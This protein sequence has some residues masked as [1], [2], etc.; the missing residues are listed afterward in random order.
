[1]GT[2]IKI[3]SGG[4]AILQANLI[5]V[6]SENGV[7]STGRGDINEPYLTPE[8]ALSDISNTG[9]ITGDTNSS[10]TLTN[11]SDV[12]N[13]LL[14]VGMQVS[15]TGIG[16]STIITAKGNE[17]GDANTITLSKTATSSTALGTITF[18]KLYT[19]VLNGEFTSTGNWLK[20]GFSYECGNSKIFFAGRLFERT[21]SEYCDLSINGGYWYGTSNLSMFYKANNTYSNANFYFNLKYLYS[22]GT[23][24]Q[25][26]MYGGVNGTSLYVNCPRFEAMFGKIASLD[27]TN[28]FWH[29]Y[30]YGLL[31]GFRLNSCSLFSDGM[32]ETPYSVNAFYIAGANANCYIND[33]VI[34]STTLFNY[35]GAWTFNGDMDGT[36]LDCTPGNYSSDLTFNGNVVYTTINMSGSGG[37]FSNGTVTFNGTLGGGTINNSLSGLL[38][39]N[40]YKGIYVGQN[41][42][43]AILT[44]GYTSNNGRGISTIDLNGTAKLTVLSHGVH[45]YTGESVTSVQVESGSHLK[46]NG[47][48]AFLLSGAMAGTLEL[49]SDSDVIMGFSQWTV[50]DITGTLISNGGKIELEKSSASSNAAAT[51]AIKLGSGGTFIMDGGSLVCNDAAVISGLIWKKADNSKVVLKGQP[52]LKTANGLAPIQ[53]TSNVGTAQ[54]IINF[55]CVTNGGVGFRLDD[56]FSDVTHGATYAPNILVGGTNYEDTTYDF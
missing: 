38:R 49:S 44:P 32:I 14:E 43:K 1:M 36:T 6:D 3:K 30:K 34:G 51:P 21:S 29:G 8:Y 20:D 27:V 45:S 9:T 28:V 41:N 18:Y 31:E 26:E 50:A 42:S 15:G 40:S 12:D 13:A 39:V 48:F 33:R 7:N 52:Y 56:T 47:Q 46:I 11:I 2:S 37:A 17:G 16:Y 54:D 19:L 53:I 22:I 5:Y 4:G 24:W 35:V 23:S 55:G 10:V 25:I